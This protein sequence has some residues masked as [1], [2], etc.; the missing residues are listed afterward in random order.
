MRYADA[1]CEVKGVG[2]YYIITGHDVFTKRKV[3]I[4]LPSQ[5]LFYYR[6]GLPIQDAMRSLSVQEREFL[7]SGMYDWPFDED[8]SDQEDE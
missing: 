4:K 7:I 6:Q 5:E 8:G 2:D 1:K 3:E